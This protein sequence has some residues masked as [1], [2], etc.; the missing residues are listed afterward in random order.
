[1]LMD[2]ERRDEERKARE[3]IEVGHESSHNGKHICD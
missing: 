2:G 3:K 1:M